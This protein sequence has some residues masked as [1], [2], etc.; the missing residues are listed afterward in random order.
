MSKSTKMGA[1]GN[2]ITN[3]GNSNEN[4]YTSSGI[5]AQPTNIWRA[6]QKLSVMCYT[7]YHTCKK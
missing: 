7:N 1:G 6:K 5:G 4:K 2:I 3:N